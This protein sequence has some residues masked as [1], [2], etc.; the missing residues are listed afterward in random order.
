MKS[1]CP[2]PDEIMRKKRDEFAK[3]GVWPTNLVG[4]KGSGKNSGGKGK[5]FLAY[6][7]DNTIDQ[8]IKP[9]TPM[10]SQPAGPGG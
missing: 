10:S 5:G 8:P 6:W 2:K 3:T 7:S 4:D 1:K 9:T